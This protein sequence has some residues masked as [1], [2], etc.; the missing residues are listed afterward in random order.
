MGWLWDRAPS[1]EESEAVF[2]EAAAF[3]AAGP[4]IRSIGIEQTPGRKFHTS[5]VIIC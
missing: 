2:K 5:V 3:Q 1:W 4:G